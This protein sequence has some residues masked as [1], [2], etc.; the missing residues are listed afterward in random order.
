V[1]K[2]R[3]GNTYYNDDHDGSD[4]PFE[5]EHRHVLIGRDAVV[6]VHVDVAER[7]V[8]QPEIHGRDV[9]DEGAAVCGCVVVFVDVVDGLD[10]EFGDFAIP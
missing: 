6:L 4:E 5:A 1:L 8:G 10:H 3:D 7:P 9:A 2:T